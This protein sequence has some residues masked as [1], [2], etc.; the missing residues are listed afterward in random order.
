MRARQNSDLA[1]DI[2][3]G[4][5]IPSI[6]PLSGFDNAT[7]HNVL[8]DLLEDRRTDFNVEFL[9][10]ESRHDRITRSVERFDPVLLD[11]NL[12]GGRQRFGRQVF[13][14]CGDCFVLL[15]RFRQVP[16]LLSTRFGQLDNRIDY[17][18]ALLVAK[19]DRTQHR[20]FVQFLGFG[21]DH[22]TLARSG[23]EIERRILKLI[24]FCQYK[25]TVNNQPDSPIGPNG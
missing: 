16:R 18:L 5:G 22:R 2:S 8:L 10:F 23:N 21:L 11:C 4:L 9:F 25:F 6:D 7:A 24:L 12:I 3:H 14:P 13:D 20:V 15:R 19:G 17:R 1:R